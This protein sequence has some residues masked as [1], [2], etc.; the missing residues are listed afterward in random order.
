MVGQPTPVATGVTESWVQTMLKGTMQ[1][2]S[3]AFI[4]LPVGGDAKLLQAAP[5]GVAKEAMDGKERQMVALGA[6]LVEQRTVQRTAAEYS[7]ETVSETSSLLSCAQNVSHGLVEALKW[8]ANYVG[9]N[10]ATIEYSLN[11][12]LDLS[13]MAP[14]EIRAIIQA[15]QAHALAKEEMRDTLRLSGYA[16]LD[17]KEFD[18]AI[19]AEIE[20]DI[21]TM[22]KIS[23]TAPQP[24]GGGGAAD[25]GRGKVTLPT[26]TPTAATA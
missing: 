2:G 6:K 22:S 14:D 19:Q 1:L 23:A 18:K 3:R 16:K 13:K 15:W 4:P 25:V 17:D 8:S 10:P 9:A 5:N 24:I 7:G 21:A 26:P 11:Q 20:E 12:E